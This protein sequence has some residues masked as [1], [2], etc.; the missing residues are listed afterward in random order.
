MCANAGVCGG[1]MLIYVHIAIM[2]KEEE[3]THLE[4]HVEVT[5]E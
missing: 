3:V 4:G 2:I 1:S 5:G